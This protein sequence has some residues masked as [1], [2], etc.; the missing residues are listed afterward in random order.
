M[1]DLVKI[2]LVEDEPDIR[3]ITQSALEL[4]GGYEVDTACN[5]LEGITKAEQFMPDLI[6]MDMMMPGMNGTSTLMEMRQND[7]IRHIPIIFMTAKVQQHE[8]SGYISLGALD[9]ISKPF[10]PMQLSEQVAQ[11]WTKFH[12]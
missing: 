5:G 10:D 11:I 3:E 2:L 7:K 9:V 12:A 4:V 6:L 8:V 1:K